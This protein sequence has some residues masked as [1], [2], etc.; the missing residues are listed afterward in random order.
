MLSKYPMRVIEYNLYNMQISV[1][2]YNMKYKLINGNCHFAPKVMFSIEII[3]L[4]ASW[5]QLLH[6][7]RFIT[8]VLHIKFFFYKSRILQT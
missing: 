8:N 1:W 4:T 5:S 6:V 3:N 7:K 2:F